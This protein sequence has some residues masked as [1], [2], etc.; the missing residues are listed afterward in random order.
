MG[1]INPRGVLSGCYRFTFAKEVT[2]L[3]GSDSVI[4]LSLS[5]FIPLLGYTVMA[6][7]HSLITK[8]S[9]QS[10][11]AITEHIICQKSSFLILRKSSWFFFSFFGLIWGMWKLPGQGLNLRHSSN[12]RSCSDNARSLTCYATR[13]F[14]S[15]SFSVDYSQLLSSKF[16]SIKSS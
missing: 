14:L 7:A 9:Y 2:T 11:S 10:P 4:V 1:F 6:P 16:V 5:D 3:E 12:L 13:E 8:C 15:D